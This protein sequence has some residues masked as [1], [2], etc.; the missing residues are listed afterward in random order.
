MDKP[1]EITFAERAA[2]K[3]T[4]RQRM[5]ARITWGELAACEA[6]LEAAHGHR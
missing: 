3:A 6:K 5:A 4:A 1:K 2:Q